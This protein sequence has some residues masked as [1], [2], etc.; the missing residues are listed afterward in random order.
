MRSDDY[1]HQCI[2][3]DA[4][5]NSFIY[6]IGQ[7]ETHREYFMVVI[8]FLWEMNY[9]NQLIYLST[10]SYYVYGIHDHE[11]FVIILV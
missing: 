2:K 8:L 10:N 7:T 3:H 4:V 11:I 5:E 9:D 6:Y 1:A